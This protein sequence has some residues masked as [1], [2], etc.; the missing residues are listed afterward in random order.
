[1]D[2]TSRRFL[3]CVPGDVPNP[4]MFLSDV[5]SICHRFVKDYCILFI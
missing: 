2:W 4:Y 1:M 5:P 3:I